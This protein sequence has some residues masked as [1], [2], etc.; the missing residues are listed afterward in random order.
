[1]EKGGFEAEKTDPDEFLLTSSPS[2]ESIYIDKRRLNAFI[3][4]PCPSQI[5]KRAAAGVSRNR[6]NLQ[7]TYRTCQYR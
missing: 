2:L 1:L 7:N 6:T 3:V 5:K 4:T